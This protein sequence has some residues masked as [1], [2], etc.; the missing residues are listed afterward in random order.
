MHPVVAQEQRIRGARNK[1]SHQGDSSTPDFGFQCSFATRSDF[2]RISRAEISRTGSRT[3]STSPG[4]TRIFKRVLAHQV[5]QFCR[6]VQLGRRRPAAMLFL[7]IHVAFAP[8][9]ALADLA[10]QTLVVRVDAL[11]IARQAAVGAL[12]DPHC[13]APYLRLRRAQRNREKPRHFG[14][15]RSPAAGPPPD[16]RVS[17]ATVDSGAATSV[18][19][20]A[21]RHTVTTPRLVSSLSIV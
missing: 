4:S 19:A 17:S 12:L 7:V 16:R 15:P 9:H 3:A 11:A 13:Q 2:L 21:F 18:R 14:S 5:F 6:P 20:V 1:P 10:Q 8:R